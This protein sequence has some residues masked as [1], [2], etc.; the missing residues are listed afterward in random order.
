MNVNLKPFWLLL[1]TNYCL[2]SSTAVIYFMIIEAGFAL[3]AI[4]L[5]TLAG[6]F[7]LKGVKRFMGNIQSS[8]SVTRF[9]S[10]STTKTPT[11]VDT[12][13]GWLEL[14][15]K[16][17]YG[18]KST[19]TTTNNNNNNSK[20]GHGFGESQESSSSNLGSKITTLAKEESQESDRQMEAITS[21]V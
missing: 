1:L 12:E 3:C 21:V 10:S 2:V 11:K 19:T 13:R 15:G 6:A 5:P 9:R 8:L 4:S 18:N 14:K 17:L 20:E 16:E 7:K